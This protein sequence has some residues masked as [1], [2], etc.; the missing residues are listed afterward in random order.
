M[1]SSRRDVVIYLYMKKGIRPLFSSLIAALSVGCSSPFIIEQNDLLLGLEIGQESLEIRT[2]K[3]AEDR[4]GMQNLTIKRSLYAVQGGQHV[5]YELA[6]TQPPYRYHYD[7]K[8]S[9]SLI[10]AARKVTQID[11]VGNLGFYAIDWN[12]GTVLLA[13]AQNL[14]KGGIKM[15]YG[16]RADQMA[17]ALRKADSKHTDA[18]EAFKAIMVLHGDTSAFKSRWVPKLLILDTL[19]TRPAVPSVPKPY[20][21][22]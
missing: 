21:P 12:E 18:L 3:V 11:R 2:E 6:V 8:R 7:V 1:N 10:F 20:P 16:L 13:I 19:I 5:V 22:K 4:I 15:I 17:Q 9:L 14:H